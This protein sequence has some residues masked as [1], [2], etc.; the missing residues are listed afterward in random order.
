MVLD[1]AKEAIQNASTHSIYFD[2]LRAGKANIKVVGCGGA[3]WIEIEERF[4]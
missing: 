4:Q 3:G 1:F 2:E